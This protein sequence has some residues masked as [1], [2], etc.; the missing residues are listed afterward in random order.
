MNANAVQDPQA[1]SI[2]LDAAR[3]TLETLPWIACFAAA[4]L[5]LAVGAWEVRAQ[6]TR[7]IEQAAS[8]QPAGSVR[9]SPPSRPT[10]A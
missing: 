9:E 8:V 3:F 10:G 5:V 4:L 1:P 6:N 7:Q 2:H